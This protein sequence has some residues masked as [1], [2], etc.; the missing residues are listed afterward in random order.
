MRIKI[1]CIGI[2]MLGI[3]LMMGLSSP[4]IVQADDPGCTN[5]DC[6]SDPGCTN[7]DCPPDPGCTNDDCP[8]DPG[9]TNDDCPSDPGCTNDDCPSDPGCTNDD[10]PPDYWAGCC[11]YEEYNEDKDRTE[12]VCCCNDEQNVSCRRSYVTDPDAPLH[13]TISDI[14]VKMDLAPGDPTGLCMPNWFI[15]YLGNAWG[16]LSETCDWWGRLQ[17]CQ[18][19]I[20]ID[21]K[22]GSEPNCL[23]INGHGVIPVAINGSEGLDVYEVDLASLQLAGLGVRVKGNGDPQCGYEDWNEDGYIDLVC[24][25]VDDPTLWS[26]ADGQAILTGYLID[27]TPIE[28]SDS[29]CVVP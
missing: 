27:G 6:P 28:G 25:F 10:C 3:F 15:A 23:N 16:P 9:C 14:F 26:P 19:V 20:M 11:C 24:Q 7:D 17:K 18:M 8:S 29:I 4:I 22:P 12:R 5:D 2:M 21:I 13:A 1:A